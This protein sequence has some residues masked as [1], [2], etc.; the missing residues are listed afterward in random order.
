MSSEEMAR[1][2]TYIILNILTSSHPSYQLND[3]SRFSLIY[4][5]N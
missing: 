3:W 2:G 4:R 5:N 1:T